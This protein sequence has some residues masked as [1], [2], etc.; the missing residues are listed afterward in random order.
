MIRHLLYSWDRSVSEQDIQ[1]GESIADF[2]RR[3]AAEKGYNT[4][5]ITPRSKAAAPKP[6]FDDD[7]VPTVDFNKSPETYEMDKVLGEID[8]VE[9]YNRWC[10]KMECDPKGKR[11]SIMV[12]CPNPAHADTHPSAWLTLDKGDGGVGNCPVC[13]IDGNGGFD[14]YDIAAWHFGFD[15]PGYKSKQ[16]FPELRALMAEDLG[17][18]VKSTNQGKEVWLEVPGDPAQPTTPTTTDPT[19]TTTS[20]TSSDT[21]SKSSEQPDLTENESEV[22]SEE[23]TATVTPIHSQ[24]PTETIE[25]PTAADMAMEKLD[26]EANGLVFNWRD[27]PGIH[28]DTFLHKWMEVT[29]KGYE[30]EE[31]YFFHGLTALSAACGN[32]VTFDESNLRLNL[33][34]C[35]IG[36]SAC[37]KSVSV[38]ALKRLLRS[39]MPF[40]QSSASGIKL[41]PSVGSGEALI[42]LFVHNVTDVN[43]GLTQT[44]PVNGLYE[45]DEMSDMMTKFKRNGN[46][47]REKMMQMYNF[48]EPVAISSRGAG[49]VEARGHYLQAITT[50]QPGNLRRIMTDADSMSGFL[51]R[52]VF[53]FGKMKR[54]PTRGRKTVDI[55]DCV[56]L[57]QKI[58]SWSSSGHQILFHDIRAAEMWDEWYDNEVRPFTEMDEN[59]VVARLDI[60]A[61]KIVGCLAAN[62]RV[63]TVTVDHVETIIMLTPYLIRTYQMVENQVGQTDL[64]VLIET[65]EKYMKKRPTEVFTVRRLSSN[66]SARKFGR[67]AIQ[68]ALEQMVKMGIIT[69]VATHRQ[70][71][72]PR[73]MWNDED[74]PIPSLRSLPSGP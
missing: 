47:A 34:T 46:T 63:E 65:I 15:V 50:T 10:K 37:G 14:K 27:L 55:S 49:T 11:E 18:V 13:I 68:A 62:D 28:P 57:L 52:W 40:D 8:I 39:A 51:N 1:P 33:N 44:L 22:S 53:I 61:M 58:H 7:L 25:L 24:E 66:T 16:G 5:P 69:T 9:A 41:L 60:L 38:N 19:P 17:Y 31:Y 21:S 67:P 6:T 42:D 2:I 43:T 23:P 35:A 72:T 73:Y 30:P 59:S 45:E 64:E 48:P 20:E 71:T 32:K 74:K 70:D 26:T 36:P 3:R 4:K 54:R 29:S 56:P 12:S